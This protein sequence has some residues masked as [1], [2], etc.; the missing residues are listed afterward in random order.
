MK[1]RRKRRRIRMRRRHRKRKHQADL[2]EL[3]P[4]AQ[5]RK[6]NPSPGES[7]VLARTF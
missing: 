4:E 6:K 2:R 3:V 7:R 5:R 1:N